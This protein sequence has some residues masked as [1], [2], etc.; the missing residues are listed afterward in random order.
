MGRCLES[1]HRIRASCLYLLLFTGSVPRGVFCE[2]S[3]QKTREFRREIMQGMIS[4]H[5]EA[6]C[7]ERSEQ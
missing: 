5:R 7:C 2:Q 1:P 6:G 4:V 3:S